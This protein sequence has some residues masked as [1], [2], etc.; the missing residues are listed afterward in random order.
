MKKLIINFPISTVFR[1]CHAVLEIS[2]AESQTDEDL[3][4][5]VR[6]Q[7][8]KE[9]WKTIVPVSAHVYTPSQVTLEGSVCIGTVN[10]VLESTGLR[11]KSFSKP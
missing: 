9:E 6:Q 5:I 2:N 3:I 1:Y 8:H 10:A 11:Y 7:L 4:Y